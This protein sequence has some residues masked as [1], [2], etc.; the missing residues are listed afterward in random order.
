MKKLKPL[1]H[2][3]NGTIGGHPFINHK[4]HA[5]GGALV[6][7]PVVQSNISSVEGRKLK[8]NRP[9]VIAANAKNA[10]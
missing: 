6:Q 1:G 4:N 10:V 9:A 5:S 2:I 8:P 7:V 3:V